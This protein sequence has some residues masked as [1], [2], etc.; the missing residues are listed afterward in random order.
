MKPLPG[1]SIFFPAYNDAKTLPRLIRDAH[2]TAKKLTDRFEII[3]VNDGS[4]D[5]TATVVT[6]LTRQYPMLRLI[7]HPVNRG[8]GGALMSGF[9]SAAY[10]WVF[11]TDG[12][13]QYD[14]KELLLLA[15][16]V[17]PDID[18]VN[19]YKTKR[20]DP[21]YRILIGTWYNAILQKIF[22][23]PIRDIDCDFRLIRASRIRAID[24]SSRSGAICLELMMKLKRTGARCT[25]VAVSHYPRASGRSQFFS[26]GRIWTT[27]TDL[28]KLSRSW[29][30]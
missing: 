30:V 4:S 9:R 22:H 14:P 13:G 5:D 7:T 2:D 17:K 11:Y 10:E 6:R 1:L 23:P 25:E 15:R 8:Y 24:L 12:D 29:I 3:I 21:W 28:L 27:F 16:R 18:V 26:F 19:G 20:H